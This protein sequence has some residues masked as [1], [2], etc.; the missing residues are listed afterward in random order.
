MKI[1]RMILFIPTAM[2]CGWLI[3]IIWYFITKW[4]LGYFITEITEGSLISETLKMIANVPAII[5][6]INAGTKMADF[7]YSD[8][9]LAGIFF[10]LGS[11]SILMGCVYNT[12]TIT[13]IISALVII[14]VSVAYMFV[15]EKIREQFD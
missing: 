8:K 10:L 15:G 12:N 13:T 5:V 1:V 2:L 7:K 14:T 3:Y 4:M 11:G 9:I 6:G